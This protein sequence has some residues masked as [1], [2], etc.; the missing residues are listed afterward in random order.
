MNTWPRSCLILRTIL[1][2]T[3][4]TE[5]DN[6]CGFCPELDFQDI[7]IGNLPGWEYIIWMAHTPN[8]CRLSLSASLGPKLYDLGFNSR[9]VTNFHLKF[10]IYTKFAQ[11][12]TNLHK[13]AQIY[14][15]LH[16][17]YTTNTDGKTD[18]SDII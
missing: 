18:L 5:F 13:F 2:K 4:T 11:I 6:K 8:E 17:I 12:C 10:K 1:T 15:N 7:D 14:A 16:K 3:G 9:A